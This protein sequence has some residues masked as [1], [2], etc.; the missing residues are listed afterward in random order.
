MRKIQTSAKY[1]ES[2]VNG[3]LDR[4]STPRTSTT[5]PQGD[6]RSTPWEIPAGCL[7]QRL[8]LGLRS[9]HALRRSDCLALLPFSVLPTLAGCAPRGL[10][11]KA[12]FAAPRGKSPRG[13]CISACGFCPVKFPRFALLRCGTLRGPRFSTPVTHFAPQSV[14]APL[15]FVAVLCGDPVCNVFQ[16]DCFGYSPYY[17]RSRSALRAFSTQGD[18][19]ST[20]W[21]I[22]AG[23]LHQRLRLLPRKVSSL[24]A[25]PLRY[26][27]GTPSAMSFNRIA[28]DILRATNAR[29]VRS[30]P[31]PRKANL[32]HPAPK[33][34]ASPYCL[35][36][37]ILP[38]GGLD[39]FRFLHIIK[40]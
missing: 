27:V 39:K 12:I 33:P 31:F 29:G 34:S 36:Q 7:H 17:Q 15:C 35:Q 32:Q 3:R 37:K 23:C 16:S 10:L 38:H 8:R 19:R 22:P 20:P 1:V 9:R 14:L 13:V 18:I 5:S 2:A 40:V 25:A 30:A 6:I 4:G 28:S 26:F 21:G 11:R 24:R